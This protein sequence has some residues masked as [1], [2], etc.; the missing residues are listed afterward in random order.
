MEER[1]LRDLWFALLER[2]KNIDVAVLGF[3][4]TRMTWIAVLIGTLLVVWGL[5]DHNLYAV[6]QVILA[7]AGGYFI[8][9]LPAVAGGI[10]VTI[11]HALIG[12]VSQ[13]RSADTVVRLIGCSYIAWLGREHQ[14][15]VRRR[16]TE[17][18][19]LPHGSHTISWALVNEVRN[20]LLGM[21][22]LLAG[23]NTDRTSTSELELV[24]SELLRLESL[25]GSLKEDS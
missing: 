12:G 25:F 2:V 10:L 13:V 21:R 7:G 5:V 16:R 9:F 11:I 1:N 8:G 4:R 17:I 20:S 3:L 15:M 23:K 19:N 6:L 14:V 18:A 22:L 24:E